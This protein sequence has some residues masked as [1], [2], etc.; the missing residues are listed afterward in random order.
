M[1][2]KYHRSH[3]LSHDFE[4]LLRKVIGN[5]LLLENNCL[6]LRN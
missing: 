1:I 3:F 4:E 2:A 6:N 5:L